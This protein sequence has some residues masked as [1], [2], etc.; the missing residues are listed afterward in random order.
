MARIN[1]G[2]VLLG[3]LVAGLIINI[4]E[5]ILNV[6]VLGAR[7]EEA[8]GALGLPPASSGA[9]G[10]FVFLGFVL[11]IIT[12]WLYAAMRTRFGPG[13]MTAFVAGLTVWFLA[14]LY[15]SVGLVAMG[16][17]PFNLTL[18]ALVWGL[19]EMILAALAGAWLYKEE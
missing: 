17:F 10:L 19:V 5:A 6:P 11:G 13:P 18:I 9:I 8:M 1:R 16:L 14:Y 3:G 4:S 12:V 2:R 7:W 15:G